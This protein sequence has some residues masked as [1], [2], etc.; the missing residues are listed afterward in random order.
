M[1]PELYGL[2]PGF[3]RNADG[4]YDLTLTKFLFNAFTTACRELGCEADEQETLAQ[5]RTILAHYPDYPTAETE[6]GT[7]FVS[8]QGEEPGVVAGEVRDVYRD[9]LRAQPVLAWL[10]AGVTTVTWNGVTN[11]NSGTGAA[12]AR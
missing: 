9:H 8:I 10:V 1:P 2:M 5:I 3:K 11:W 12:P 4:L 7:T 6:L